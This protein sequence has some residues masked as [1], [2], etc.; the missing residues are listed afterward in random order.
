THDNKVMDTFIIQDNNGEAVTAP[1]MIA[2][3]EKRLLEALESDLIYEGHSN[4]RRPR[5]LKAFDHPTEVQFEQDYLNS[6]TVMEISALDMPGLLSVIA[7]VI[8]ELDINIT[9]AKISTLGEK[10]DDIFY[11]T[12]PERNAITDQTLLERLEQNL[13][14]ALEARK[15]A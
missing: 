8:A 5:H 2:R 13:V 10:V 7:N 11:L 3:I 14:A 4:T 1:D 9:H 6:R 15:A 12:T